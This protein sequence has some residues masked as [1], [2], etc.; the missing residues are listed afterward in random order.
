VELWSGL[1]E[2]LKG[3]LSLEKPT[4]RKANLFIELSSVCIDPLAQLQG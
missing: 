4:D 1:A 3:V 2:H